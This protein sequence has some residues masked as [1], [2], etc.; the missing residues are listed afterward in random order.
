ACATCHSRG[1]V[2]SG[3]P[4]FVNSWSGT[5]GIFALHRSD[6]GFCHN[7]TRT[8]NIGI[9]FTSVSDV[10][11]NGTTV[12]CLNCHANRATGHG[13]HNEGDGTFGWISSCQTCHG[14]GGASVAAP[15]GE[16]MAGVHSNNCA[17]CHQG[18]APGAT[19]IGSAAN[20]IGHLKPH[21]CTDCHKAG[22]NGH[23][24]G[25]T[26]DLLMGPADIVN[27]GA[28]CNECHMRGGTTST[29]PLFTNTWDGVDGILALH[30]GS[31]VL[32]HNSTRTENLS[33][34]YASVSDV[35]RLHTATV[36]CLDCHADRAETHSSHPAEDFTWSGTC[37]ACHSGANIAVN[38]HKGKC[39][40]C[41]VNVNGGGVKRAGKDGSALLAEALPDPRTAS[42]LTC[43]PVATYRTSGIHH[44]T[45]TA[46]SN[47]CQICHKAINH[48]TLVTNVTSC[49]NCHSNTAGTTTGMPVDVAN[50]RVHDSCLTCHT[51]NATTLAG[52]LVAP[53]GKKG[54][55]A[56]GTGSCT[57]CHTNTTTMHHN[58][59]HSKIG[60]CEYC[61]ADPRNRPG[62]T[63]FQETTPSGGLPTHLPCEECHVKP[64]RGAIVNGWTATAGQMTIYAFNEGGTHSTTDYSS[65]FTRTVAHSGTHVI[66]NT[67]GQINNWGICFSCHD[68]SGGA[69]KAGR[70]NI[71]HAKP[72]TYVANRNS[73]GSS[74][75]AR[76]APG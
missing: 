23:S 49:S 73:C 18:G 68:G 1:G 64:K 40:L 24:H 2:G 35:I 19:L 57:I 3:N 8:T 52:Q 31:C 41:H 72:T 61:H 10:I 13:G 55:S 75:T 11:K 59:N 12:A 36:R 27:N 38:V 45:R 20:A 25:G 67:V 44:D 32:C 46:A 21:T 9:G 60:E 43:H 51:F 70:V 4:A 69:G 39:G 48:S 53:T 15:K 7:S 14:P 16:I 42:C 63:N 47:D 76:Y 29:N 50:G 17:K 56:M 22:F 37:N 5:D 6:C 65:D 62:G 54:V 66:G 74:G 34:T 33:G 28:S 30:K 71:F 58:N 26:H